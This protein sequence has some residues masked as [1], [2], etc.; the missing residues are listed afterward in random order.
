[1]QDEMNRGERE[2]ETVLA[3]IRPAAMSASRDELLFRAGAQSADRSRRG[4]LRLWQSI[5]AV[6]LVATTV[7]ILSRPSP[8]PI[9]YFGTRPNPTAMSVP[10]AASRPIDRYS[11]IAL[12]DAVLTDGLDALPANQ[13]VHSSPSLGEP[14]TRNVSFQ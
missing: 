10:A 14:S 1:M 9:A 8:A 4:K 7:S 13:S 3:R 6:L 11:A 5:A 12:R 2:L